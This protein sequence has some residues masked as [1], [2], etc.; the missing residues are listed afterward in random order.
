MASIISAHPAKQKISVALIGG[1]ISGLSC[2]LQLANAMEQLQITQSQQQQTQLQITIFDKAVKP[3]GRMATKTPRIKSLTEMGVKNLSNDDIGAVRFDHG[4][5]YFTV[6]SQLMEPLFANMQS[7]GIV[8][9]WKGKIKVMEWPCKGSVTDTTGNLSRYVG[10]PGMN[11]IPEY[12]SKVL[13]AKKHVKIVCDARIQSVT[14]N[15]DGSWNLSGDQGGAIDE[16]KQIKDVNF[17]DFD[18]VV[19]AM[20][21][22]QAAKLLPSQSFAE[23]AAQVKMGGCWCGMLAFEQPQNL[24][25]DGAFVNPPKGNDEHGSLGSTD[26]K[27]NQQPQPPVSWIARN[28][29]KPR[30]AAESGKQFDCWVLHS[31]AEFFDE[32]SEKS[33]E[34]LGKMFSEMFSQLQSKFSLPPQKP[35]YATAHRWRY[36]YPLKPLAEPFFWDASLGIG[37]CGDWFQASRVEGAYLS[38]HNLGRQ[39]CVDLGLPPY[40]DVTDSSL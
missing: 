21:P 20:P 12:I 10:L 27:K 37:A 32:H 34:E 15:D 23:K 4:A 26:D 36:S 8:D 9:A 17:G 2:A 31:S 19:V 13:G 22:E 1:G 7:K 24:P 30:R 5:Q 16:S 18:C 29:S 33:P 11:A 28:N 38:G 3:G 14:R 40:K 39:M 25:F 6:R 35:V